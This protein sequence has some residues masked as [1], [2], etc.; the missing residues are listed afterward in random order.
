MVLAMR[1]ECEDEGDKSSLG[2]LLGWRLRRSR[3]VHRF[4]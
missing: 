4:V 1:T 3:I 2:R